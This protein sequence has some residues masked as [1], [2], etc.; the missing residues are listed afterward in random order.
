V[1]NSVPRPAKALALA[2]IGIL[3]FFVLACTV[4]WLWG[5]RLLGEWG[6]LAAVF[7]FTNIPPVLA[8][9]GLATMDMA[10]GAAVCAALYT[11][12]RWLDEPTLKR[13]MLFG[14]ALA[15]AFLSKFS[16]VLLMP[17][18]L[19]T[20]TLLYRPKL[21]GRNWAWIPAFAGLGRTG[22]RSTHNDGAT[23]AR[24]AALAAKRAA[25]GAPDPGWI[26]AGAWSH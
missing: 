21:R 11:F 15:M 13:S 12:A 3:P 23:S 2:R 18:C 22:F 24:P 7:L 20:L 14:A 8:H 5:R 1:L 16:S 17:V 25:A 4:V 10:I 6:A 26:V 19:L 9:A